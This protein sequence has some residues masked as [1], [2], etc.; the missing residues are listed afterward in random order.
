[1]I[2]VEL[3]AT[4]YPSTV[5]LTLVKTTA[6]WCNDYYCSD[7]DQI[8]F[9]RLYLGNI[10][11]N[12]VERYKMDS[13]NSLGNDSTGYNWKNCEL[14]QTLRLSTVYVERSI[15]KRNCCDVPS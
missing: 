11:I 7:L 9:L 6:K 10:D 5:N 2:G 3:I 14:K 4:I 1:M 12:F 13:G 8:I 15:F